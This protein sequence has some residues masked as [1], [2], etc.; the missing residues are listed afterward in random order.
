RFMSMQV[1]DEDHYV[2]AVV[3]RAGKHT[4]TKEQISTR[5]FLTVVRTLVDLNDPKDMEQVHKLQDAI[6]VE[7]KSPGHFKVPNWDQASQ[8]KIRDALLVLGSPLPDP[9]RTSAPKDQVDPVR[10]LIGTAMAW[11]GNPEKDAIYLNVTPSKNDGKT[12]Y[13]LTVKDVPV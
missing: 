2:P 3:Y 9:N 11:G 4:F 12:I 1:I 6:K 5:Y 10:H 7:Q 13:R 8:K